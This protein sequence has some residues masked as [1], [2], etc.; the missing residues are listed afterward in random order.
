MCVYTHMYIYIISN[1]INKDAFKY[2]HW[3]QGEH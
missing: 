2:E 1:N 3:D